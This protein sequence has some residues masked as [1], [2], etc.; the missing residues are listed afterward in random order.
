MI[1][2]VARHQPITL[3]ADMSQPFVH[4]DS[5]IGIHSRAVVQ[6]SPNPEELAEETWQVVLRYQFLTK[7]ATT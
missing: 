7:M 5:S 6:G 3:I 4:D 1:A 2:G